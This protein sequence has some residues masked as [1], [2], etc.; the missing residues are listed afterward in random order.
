MLNF[1]RGLFID[2]FLFSNQQFELFYSLFVGFLFAS[3][4]FRKVIS[5]DDASMFFKVFVYIHIAGLLFSFLTGIGRYELTFIAYHAQNMDVGGTGFLIGMFCVYLWFVKKRTLTLI[6]IIIPLSLLALTGSRSN[7][8]LA[9]I[10]LIMKYV[11]ESKKLI[12]EYIKNQTIAKGKSKFLLFIPL[13]IIFIVMNWNVIVEFSSNSNTMPTAKLFKIVSAIQSGKD[14]SDYESLD[15]SVYGRILS[16]IAGIKILVKNPLGLSFSFIDLQRHMQENGYPTFP[17]STFLTYYLLM[18][19]LFIVVFIS[20]ISLYFRLLRRSNNFH[21]FLLYIFVY[22]LFFGGATT[23]F[24]I[25]FL[26]IYILWWGRKC[27][28]SENHRDNR[29]DMVQICKTA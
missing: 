16:N 18:G 21:F 20:F 7:L 2:D 26:Y 12:F 8:Y 17:H 5:V 11:L 10:F 23:N 13:I 14:I 6:E 25:Y 4:I 3:L 27:L 15:D 22:S 9:L 24:K 29:I 19:I 28:D 1:I